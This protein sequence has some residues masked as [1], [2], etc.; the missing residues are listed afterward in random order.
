MKTLILLSLSITSLHSFAFDHLPHASPTP[1]ASPSAPPSVSFL[2]S[3]HQQSLTDLDAAKKDLADATQST[4]W[5]ACKVDQLQTQVDYYTWFNTNYGVFQAADTSI[6]SAL[7]A[8]NAS[9]TV[10][11][12]SDLPIAPN[13][14]TRVTL[15][16]LRELFGFF[17]TSAKDC[18]QD[19]LTLFEKQTEN[20]SYNKLGISSATAR[21]LVDTF[22]SQFNTSAPSNA[23]L[24]V[25]YRNY[26]IQF[27]ILLNIAINN[28]I[29]TLE[30]DV[31]FNTEGTIQITNQMVWINLE[32]ADYHLQGYAVSGKKRLNRF[33]ADHMDASCQDIEWNSVEQNNEDLVVHYISLNLPHPAVDPTHAAAAAAPSDLIEC[34]AKFR[35]R[36]LIKSF[37]KTLMLYCEY[38]GTI[39]RKDCKDTQNHEFAWVL[40]SAKTQAIPFLCVQ[41]ENYT[42]PKQYLGQKITA[43]RQQI[44]G[45]EDGTL[46]S[47][48]QLQQ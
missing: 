22:V 5:E 42:K 30:M 8:V 25:H 23:R 6:T 27:K 39:D 43:L 11:T 21:S 16:Q 44:V 31:D 19:Q 47:A 7:T 14:T 36:G 2:E 24:L 4:T 3:M 38:D 9:L 26:G 35:G 13:S 33:K 18:S 29:E 28:K 1:T 48:Q 12:S 45:R 40:E 10:L 17:C 32:D 41:I 34:P 20:P 46:K 37:N 15:K